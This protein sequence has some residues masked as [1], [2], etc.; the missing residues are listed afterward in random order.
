M[1]KEKL[2]TLIERAGICESFMK[3]LTI[4]FRCGQVY[5]LGSDGLCYVEVIHQLR[6]HQQQSATQFQHSDQRTG[7]QSDS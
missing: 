6:D 3:D 7:S 4:Y 5:V 1:F 2:K